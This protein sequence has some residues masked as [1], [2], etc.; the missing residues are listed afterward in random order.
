MTWAPQQVQITVFTLLKADTSLATLLNTTV[1]GT[2]KIF[3]FVPDNTD[4]PFVVIE[5]KPYEDR[6]S[7]TTE[8]LQAEISIHT[9]YQP[10]GSSSV[11]GRGD[12]QVQLIQSRIDQLLHKQPVTI[13]GWNA[14]ILRRSFIDIVVDPDNVTRHGIQKFKLFLGGQ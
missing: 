5:S 12:K 9:W 2:Q 3:D 4:F 10:G 13:S 8:G 1:S 7:Y 6:G 14:L 11:S